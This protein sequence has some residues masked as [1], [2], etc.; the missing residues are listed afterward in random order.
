[1]ADQGLFS[2]ANFVVNVLLARWL[3]PA[4]YGAFAVALSIFYLLAGF[5]SAVLTEPM[6]VFGAGRYREHFREYLGMLLYG[7]WGI[8]AIVALALGIAAFVF[9][10]Y[11][12]PAIA[13]GLAGL[14]VASPF[15]LFIW[16]VRRACYV[17]MQLVWAMMG[18]G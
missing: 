18:S 15:L 5:H 16:L 6:M 10:R 8:S 12:S 13:N 1:M 17:P 2:G 9:A 7:H 14:A 4:E 11:G 3:S